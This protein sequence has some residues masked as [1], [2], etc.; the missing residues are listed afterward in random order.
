M[1]HNQGRV[2][3]RPESA[4]LWIEYRTQDGRKVRRSSKTTSER[5][6]R[7]LLDRE[8]RKLEHHT[9][10][11]AVVAFFETKARHLKGSTLKCYQISLRNVDPFLGHLTLEEV[12][13]EVLKSFIAARRRKGVTDATIKR[14]LAFVSSVFSNAIETLPKGPSVNPV[15]M[16]PKRG[17]KENP[18]SRWLRKSEFERLLEAC[19]CDM[20][21][22]II[23]TA[24]Y[25]GMRHGEL[26]SLRKHHLDFHRQEV[27]LDPNITKNGKER[28]VPLCDWLC[29]ELEQLCSTTPD[30]LV[31]C[32]QD[33]KTGA[34]HPYV[35]FSNWWKGVRSRS[36]VSDLR[37]HDLRH[38]FASWFM[39]GGGDIYTLRGLLGHSSISTSQ[40][41]AHLNTGSLH[42]AIRHIFDTAQGNATPG[43]VP[44]A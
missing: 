27:R 42:Q 29:L 18:R 21:R 1:Q 43:E 15:L 41:Y 9:F 40:G 4:Y 26:V 20:Q 23:K 44:S 11:S 19:S 14:D 5:E 30:D 22:M 38:T 32:Y 8:I 16:F 28:I 31:F 25:T 13:T 35:S 6:A 37:F 24:V 2:Y 7:K 12:S 3:S 33:L 36:R 17:L 10:R 34:Y 39:Q